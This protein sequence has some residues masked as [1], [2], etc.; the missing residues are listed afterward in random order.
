MLFQ[1]T[2]LYMSS[3]IVITKTRTDKN[4]AG[5]NQKLMQ[6]LAVI[7]ICICQI[8]NQLI[9]RM[10]V[11]ILPYRPPH[12]DQQI[13]QQNMIFLKNSRSNDQKNSR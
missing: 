3:V 6:S 5:T 12:M 8:T 9:A 10:A 2:F 7:I 1:K 11:I 4:P 13:V